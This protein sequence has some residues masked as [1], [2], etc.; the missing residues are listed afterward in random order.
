M[1]YHGRRLTYA[2]LE[3]RAGRLAARLH[4]E[5]VTRGTRVG[6]CAERS[7]ELVVALLGVLK[8]GAS[9]IPLDPEYPAE[10]LQFMREDAEIRVVLAH[11]PTMDQVPDGTEV[12]INSGRSNRT[13]RTCCWAVPSAA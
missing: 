7:V 11:T 2:S 13:A 3:D 12:V 9:F 1:V 4:R 5:G 8:A 10:G 6:I